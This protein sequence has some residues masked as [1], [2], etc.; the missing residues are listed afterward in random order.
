MFCAS[1]FSQ[2]E[3]NIWYFGINAGL[4]FNSDPPTPLLDL[5]IGSMFSSEGCSSISDSDGTL[6]FFTN[7]EKVWNKNYQIMTNGDDLAGHNSA[8]QSSAIIPYPGTYNFAENRFDRYFLVTLDDY[9]VNSNAV[10]DKGVRYS[11]IDMTMDNEL[12]VVTQNK[13]I[14]LFGTTTTEKVCVVPHSNG[15][16]YWVIC[17]VV[18]SS[19]FYVYHISSSGFNTTPVVS[20]TN[21]FVD[22]RPGQM[23]V[24]PNNKLLSYVVPPSSPFQGLYLFHF[25][26]STGVITEKF[27]D[28]TES[29]N[30]Y[31]T[32]FSPNSEVLYKSGGNRISQYDVT[33]TTNEAFIAS[34]M[35]FTTT[36]SGLQSMQLGPDDK[37]YIARPILNSSTGGLGVINN[38]NVLGEDCNYVPQQQDLGGRLC[39]AG[40]PNQLIN[41]KPHNEIVVE[42]EDCDSVQFALENN[43]TIYN[44]SWELVYATNP[45]TL[46]STSVEATPLFIIPNPN[47]E[48]LITCSVVSECY[49]TTYKLLFSLNNGNFTTPSFDSLAKTYCQN[50]N[51][52]VLPLI[53]E[54]GTT[55]TWFPS[56]ITTSNTGTFPYTFT[57]DENQC[58]Y[59]VIVDITVEPPVSVNFVDTAICSGD[60]LNFPDTNTI[61]GSWFP[62]SISSTIGNTYIFTPSDDC[63]T[64]T[65][66]TVI[67][68]EK[69]QVLFINRTFCNGATINFPNTNGVEGTWSPAI[70]SNSQSAI[71]TFTPNGTC[72]QSTTWE[73]NIAESFTNLNTSIRNNNTV[74]ATVENA[75]STVLFQL[76][77]GNFQ[78]SNVFE[79]VSSGCHTVNVKDLYGCTV[80]SSSVFVFDYPKFFTPNGD[81]YNEYWNIVLKNT[82]TNLYIFDRYGKLLKQIR[83]NEL[84]WDGMYNGQKLPATDYWFVL[85]YEGC[86]IKKTFKSHFSL[87]R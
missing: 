59:S 52:A 21:F 62:S 61:S 73:V 76:D 43:N 25:D 47:E 31:G 85:E 64:P 6:L 38:P 22:A 65:Q 19:D 27:A 34:K 78:E 83:Q 49:S 37:I 60:P 55:G 10:E 74:V 75:S 44:Y 30:Q 12:G 11:E 51:P 50:Q 18:D 5:T 82:K 42:N 69:K 23:K 41:L 56:E 4:D 14:L 35:I 67:I 45:Q 46:I 24:S 7:G 48:Y 1:A 57:P 77:N 33:T 8:T 32:A 54:D 17:K 40:L 36:T 58:A 29:E 68:N 63:G 26:N 86:G 70:L 72:V 39:L 87:M 53:S 13:N 28:S 81:G 2:G 80:L 84:G 16:D 15:C 66:W 20:T 71:Y 9:T 3:A 79:N